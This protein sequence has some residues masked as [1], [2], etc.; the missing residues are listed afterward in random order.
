MIKY[1]ALEKCFCGV[2]PERD[3]PDCRTEPRHLSHFCV[4]PMVFES[5]IAFPGFPDTHLHQSLNLWTAAEWDWCFPVV[6]KL[7]FRHDSET[8]LYKI[9]PKCLSKLWCNWMGHENVRINA[10]T[11]AIFMTRSWENGQPSEYAGKSGF[12]NKMPLSDPND[13]Q[14]NCARHGR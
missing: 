12:H 10:L 8:L 14:N 9:A 4:L 7:A 6:S 13:V 11:A 1:V 5:R 3:R 2:I